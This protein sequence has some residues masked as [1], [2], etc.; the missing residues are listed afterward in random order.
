VNTLA[1]A[2]AH[3]RTHA[4]THTHTHARTHTH[5]H[6]HTSTHNHL[7]FDSAPP[8]PSYHHWQATTDALTRSAALSFSSSMLPMVLTALHSRAICSRAR[9]HTHTHTLCDVIQTDVNDA[10]PIGTDFLGG[11]APYAD[12]NWTTRAVVIDEHVQY[13]R[14]LLHF[15][16]EDPSVPAATR[17]N[18]SG[19]GLCADEWVASGGWPP[20]LYVRETRRMRGRYVMTQ[21]CSF[22]HPYESTPPLSMSHT[23]PHVLSSQPCLLTLVR[24]CVLIN[25]CML[26]T[27]LSSCL[28]FVCLV[29]KADRMPFGGS[30]VKPDSVCLG[31]YGFDN[32]NHQRIAQGDWV[33]NE[34]MRS[35]SNGGCAYEVTDA[36]WS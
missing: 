29:V 1:C 21:V 8:P 13:T 3:T 6:T 28:F 10:G 22:H 5:T 19:W 35:Y 31:S 9:T 14:G 30:R 26:F 25:S 33:Y 12:G 36:M 23:P 7:P 32:H 20:Q 27:F 2:R 4:H 34:G 24:P 17:A 18:M 11:S 15:W 16:R